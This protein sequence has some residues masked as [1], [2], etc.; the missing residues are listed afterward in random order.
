MKAALGLVFLVICSGL[1][2]QSLPGELLGFPELAQDELIDAVTDDYYRTYEPFNTAFSISGS[3][4]GSNSASGYLHLKKDNWQVRGGLRGENSTLANLQLMFR[5]YA[6]LGA[7]RVSWGNGLLLNRSTYTPAL[8]NPPNPQTFSLSGLAFNL[9]KGNWGLLAALSQVD[10]DVVLNEGNISQLPKNKR[11]YLNSSWE[12]IGAI[13]LYY[14]EEHTAAGALYYRQG[15]DRGFVNA[16]TDSLLHA[17]SAYLGMHTKHHRLM[18]ELV[19]QDGSPSLKADWQ[20]SQG[21]VQSMWAYTMMKRYQRPA[22]ASKAMLISSLDRREELRAEIGYQA[23]KHMNIAFGTVLNNRRGDV[24]DPDWLAHNSLKLTY[25]DQ[26]SMLSMVIKT[27]DREILAMVDSTYADSRPNHWR[28]ALSAEH[29]LNPVWDIQMKARYHHQKHNASLRSGSY[30]AQHIGYRHRVLKMKVGIA[31]SSSVNYKMI[32]YQDNDEGYEILGDSTLRAEFES[33]YQWRGFS[34]KAV[35]YQ[36]MV[37]PQS[38]GITLK[39][40]GSFG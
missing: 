22:Y 19:L 33:T 35:L 21:K 6:V 32:L 12:R 29:Q 28:F 16:E 23:L 11:N 13:G 10:R 27:I 7:Y 37:K 20:F 8:L 26:H 36:N 3:H 24:S 30:W 31:A 9:N 4:T 38:T 1:C 40:N 25:R 14:A 39:L 18:T 2:A 17:F 5:D 34:L 15:Y